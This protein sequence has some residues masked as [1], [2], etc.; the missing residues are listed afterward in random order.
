YLDIN[1]LIWA[2]YCDITINGGSE[3]TAEINAQLVGWDIKLNGNNTITFNYDPSNQVV[4]KN[5]VG[6][7]R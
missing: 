1:G 4:I 5:K 3:P 2:P 7:M 6:L